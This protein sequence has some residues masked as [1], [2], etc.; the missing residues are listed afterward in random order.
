MAWNRPTTGDAQSRKIKPKSHWIK[1]YWVGATLVI[2]VTMGALF[3]LN[4]SGKDSVSDE[5]SPREARPAMISVTNHVVSEERVGDVR[6]TTARQ[7]KMAEDGL[8]LGK[9][10]TSRTAVTNAANGRIIETIITEDGGKHTYIR[11]RDE[12]TFIAGTTD[13][14]LAIAATLKPGEDMPPIPLDGDLE[15]DFEECL[16]SP[17]VIKET[18]TPAVKAQKELLMSM[19]ERISELRKKGYTVRELLQEHVDLINDNAEIHN[20]ARKELRGIIRSGKLEDARTFLNAVNEE[21]RKM[22]ADELRC[23]REIREYEE[24]ELNQ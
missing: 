1:C 10:I 6:G 12:E 3:L 8:W 15:R 21:L 9:K 7:D 23:P 2:G 4:D 17:I 14:V 20:S 24:R 19:R 13:Q 22:G 5:E 16:K 18:D 11:E